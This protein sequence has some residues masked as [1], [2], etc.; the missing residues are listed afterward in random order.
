[1]KFIIRAIALS[2]VIV[3]SSCE[4]E[5]SSTTTTSGNTNPN[6]NPT[7]SIKK[8]LPGNWS[9]DDVSQEEGKNFLAGTSTLVSTFTGVGENVQ[10]SMV[11][12]EAPEAVTASVAYDMKLD[13]AF[14][15]PAIPNQT[16]T[17]PGPDIN[18]S[19]TWEFDADSSIVIT[20][21][22]NLKTFYNVESKTASTLELSTPVNTVIT[23]QS[24]GF[25]LHI[26]LS[27]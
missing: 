20:D 1:M 12:S 23:G 14:Q 5:S 27:K 6:T 26:F 8:I 13:I 2:L 17:I 21:A 25:S 24:G 9:V 10:G 19:G 18:L 3:V 7:L 16:L 22:N 11:F 15:S 4:E